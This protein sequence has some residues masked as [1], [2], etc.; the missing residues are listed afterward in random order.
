MC[1][2][3]KKEMEERVY[4]IDIFLLFWI[5]IV[6]IIFGKNVKWFFRFYGYE[7]INK[8]DVEFVWWDFRYGLCNSDHER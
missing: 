4:I 8:F 6:F 2:I 3:I 5:Y 1:K 7:W